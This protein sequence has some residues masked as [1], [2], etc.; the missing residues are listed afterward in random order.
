MSVLKESD[1]E[2]QYLP[3]FKSVKLRDSVYHPLCYFWNAKYVI[4]PLRNAYLILLFSQYVTG[5][6]TEYFNLFSIF[7]TIQL[8]YT[9][10]NLSEDQ[11]WILKGY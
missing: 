11:N 3:I 8:F 7:L 5:L 6:F 9:D 4:T 2:E 10:E 1:I